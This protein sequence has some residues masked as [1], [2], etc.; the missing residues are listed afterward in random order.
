MLAPALGNVVEY[1]PGLVADA[2]T[3]DNG[4]AL[5]RALLSPATK[6]TLPRGTFGYKG[7][8]TV[9][10]GQRVCGQSEGNRTS[11][12]AA[13][14]GACTALVPA[15]GS[16]FSV[17]TPMILLGSAKKG[18]SLEHL[19]V[20][21]T[22]GA[23]SAGATAPIGVEA[24][25]QKSALVYVVVAGGVI[26]VL[27]FNTGQTATKRSTGLIFDHVS[28][29]SDALCAVVSG[30]GA[31]TASLVTTV[32]IKTVTPT[33]IKVGMVMVNRNT[34]RALVAPAIVTAV[35][36]KTVGAKTCKV[37]CL[38]TT[39]VTATAIVDF[40]SG[41]TAIVTSD[42]VA[43]RLHTPG[44]MLGSFSGDFQC[45]NG[46]HSCTI[47]SG[48]TNYG[49]YQRFST[50]GARHIGCTFD[51]KPTD[52]GT[53]LGAFI[54][55]VQGSL[56]VSGCLFENGTT[57]AVT[58]PIVTDPGV[59]TTRGT[60]MIGCHVGKGVHTKKFTTLLKRSGSGTKPDQLIGNDVEPTA[61]V[62]TSTKP[63]QY[64]G[65]TPAVVRSNTYKGTL[66]TET[67][68]A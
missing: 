43:T 54:R 13:T 30:K 12:A 21:P 60:K 29:R 37:T 63:K 48:A 62:L 68:I 65:T 26:P 47:T 57:A 34:A 46:H 58:V 8:L 42:C 33:L 66:L 25:G 39:S 20:Y 17:A 64:T 11:R 1:V 45:V 44:G 41:A 35:S 15:A 22:G 52:D 4:P 9:S 49:L 40:I 31:S 16:S 36:T 14:A 38:H 3:T 32:S 67:A 19:A 5:R 55:R 56:T 10:V 27:A 59:D 6:V 53:V 28:S 2:G 18:G 61:M 24:Q 50:A 51:G 23:N 7:T